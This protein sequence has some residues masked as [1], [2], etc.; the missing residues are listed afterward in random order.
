MSGPRH[1]GRHAA[2]DHLVMLRRGL[3]RLRAVEASARAA[4]LVEFHASHKYLLM[5]HGR[6]HL[7]TLGRL[8]AHLNERPWR[9]VVRD[10]RTAFTHALGEPARPA[11]SVDALTHM[12]GYVSQRLNGVERAGFLRDL[13]DLR[14]GRLAV[15]DLLAA[16]HA[17]ALHFD[18]PYLLG[19]AW[20]ELGNGPARQP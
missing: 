5:A 19:Q 20:F 12:F 1:A 11:S 4:E 3:A 17:W 9:D 10:Y 8:V 6:S 18:E 14:A 7:R 13:E 16:L 2:V 15:T